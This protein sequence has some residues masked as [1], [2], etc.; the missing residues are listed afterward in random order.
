MYDAHVD[1]HS[2]HFEELRTF[3]AKTRVSKLEM[4][5]STL[6]LIALEALVLGAEMH[7][8][9]I[10]LVTRLLSSLPHRTTL[11]QCW[12]ITVQRASEKQVVLR[13]HAT[14]QKHSN[15]ST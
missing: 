3:A 5:A 11:R 7:V 12:C 13:K 2:L 9:A 14:G 15:A 8:S 10:K 4:Y 6:T 1:G